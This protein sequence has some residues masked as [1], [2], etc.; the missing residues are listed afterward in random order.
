MLEKCKKNWKKH[1]IEVCIKC[2]I[3][4]LILKNPIRIF[5]L[6]SRLIN[7]IKKSFQEQRTCFEEKVEAIQMDL[8][9]CFSIIVFYLFQCCVSE[10]V[11]SVC[12]GEVGGNLTVCKNLYTLCECIL[13]IFRKSL[14]KN[15]DLEFNFWKNDRVR[16]IVAKKNSSDGNSIRFS[17]NEFPQ[18]N[19]WIAMRLWEI[20]E[21]NGILEKW[22]ISKDKNLIKMRD[23]SMNQLWCQSCWFLWFWQMIL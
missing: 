2:V 11:G 18:N 13:W 6:L 5:N 19:M 20:C 7:Q 22:K 4:F 23:F 12:F 21:I 15:F 10:S 1:K 16:R 8:V 3:H 9:W 17:E 14:F